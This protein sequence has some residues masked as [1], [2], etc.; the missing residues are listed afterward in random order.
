MKHLIDR[1]RPFLVLFFCLSA[2]LVL[3]ME[4]SV[5]RRIL[6]PDGLPWSSLATIF[7]DPAIWRNYALFTGLF[8][9]GIVLLNV[10]IRWRKQPEAPSE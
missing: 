7:L 6:S 2:S 9:A 1:N 3:I 10:S 5:L 4:I 8:W